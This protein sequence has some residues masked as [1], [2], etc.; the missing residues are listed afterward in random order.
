L[1]LSMAM[2][3][4]MHGPILGVFLRQYIVAVR[5][6]LPLSAPIEMFIGLLTAL[7]PLR[8]ARSIHSL[9][10]DTQNI[11]QPILRPAS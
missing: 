1:D 8:V 9:I 7:R 10:S 5:R 2:R 11:R 6:G 4:C 3:K